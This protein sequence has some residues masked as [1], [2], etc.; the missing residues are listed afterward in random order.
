M[1]DRVE[2]LLDLFLDARLRGSAA[3]I[4]SLI[5]AHPGLEAVERDRLRRLAGLVGAERSAPAAIS[6][7]R[8]GPYRIVR[9][10]GRGGQGTVYLAED[11]RFARRVALKVLPDRAPDAPD[12]PDARRSAARLKREAEVVS[13]LDHP[14]ICVVHEMGSD[15]GER[16]IAMRYVEGETLARKIAASTTDRR[17]VDRILNLVERCA[18]AL[19]V[20][21]E[22]GVVHRDVKPGNIMVTPEGEPVI[23]DFGLA[24][25]ESHA[26]SALTLSGGILGTPAYLSPEQ[27]SSSGPPDRRS[28]VYAL[29]VT[30]YECL[31]HERPFQAPTREQL[32]RRILTE[33]TPDARRL[34]PSV[35]GDLR[36]V[37]ATAMEKDVD[38]RYQTA[39]DLAEELRRVRER[40]PILARPPGIATRGA[41]W[42]QRNP[43]LATMI[44]GLFL[45]LGAALYA[46]D[47]AR[48]ANEEAVVR[49]LLE[50]SRGALASNPGLSLLLAIEAAERRPGLAT[51]QMLLEAIGALQERRTFEARPELLQCLPSPDG[52]WLA[53]V[54][55]DGTVEVR[56][57]EDWKLVA[58][59]S[60]H[61]GG[62]PTAAFSAD[63]NVLAVAGG[64][65][66]CRIWITSSWSAS[67]VIREPSGSLMVWDLDATGRHLLSSPS[68]LD[69][70][71]VRHWDIERSTSQ[72]I[73]ETSADITQCAFDRDGRRVLLVTRSA[74]ARVWRLDAEPPRFLLGVENTV[75]DQEIRAV[76]SPD[77]ERVL[78]SFQQNGASLWEVESARR[79]I[80]L[81]PE[82]HGVAPLAFSADGRRILV[83]HG[84]RRGAVRDASSGEVVCQLD[85]IGSSGRLA[86]FRAD[87]SSVLA[88]SIGINAGLWDAATGESLTEFLGHEDGTM[89][90]YFSK[91]GQTVITSSWDGTVREWSLEPERERTTYRASGGEILRADFDP[92]GTPLAVTTSLG[93][94]ERIDVDTGAVASS[95]P[96]PGPGA[97]GALAFSPDGRFVVTI[98]PRRDPPFAFG[99][100]A[101]VRDAR[102]G[103]RTSEFVHPA[104]ALVYDARFS[105]NGEF[106]VTAANDRKA[107]IW[108]ARTGTLVQELVGHVGGVR[109]AAF[110]P[111]GERIV[112]SSETV[113]DGTVRIW[114]AKSGS[115]L[116]VLRAEADQPMDACFSPD[117]QWAAAGGWNG[118]VCLWDTSRGRLLWRQVH[119]KHVRSVAF[120]PD[121]RWILTASEDPGA[122]LL[123]RESGRSVLQLGPRMSFHVSAFSADGRWIVAASQ[124]DGAAY[125]WPADPLQRAREL[126]PRMLTAAECARYG[127]APEED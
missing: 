1:T 71:V 66:T 97:V 46:L 64:D 115:P 74:G 96:C 51:N 110:D 112:T 108:D 114:D 20:A 127:L 58:T 87:G 33:S 5:A 95:F 63:G 59:L 99:P 42:T 41:R 23:L 45:A 104:D 27:I 78:V 89:G 3:D 60:G 34:N 105:P 119:S 117:G 86:F 38:H 37:L 70:G 123:E 81:G 121:G 12:D 100:V 57:A 80:D 90:A 13:R 103:A 122:Q 30:L 88:S 92:A 61:P 31:T 26:T 11:S 75:V 24:S 19:H 93:S 44:A 32:Y 25:D 65:G 9:E 118:S 73:A 7:E 109:S 21:H 84:A 29:G 82:S 107:R 72:V 43:V 48:T 120:S 76:F 50:G 68:P 85:G 83:A 28:D 56:D 69:S 8:I 2:D 111:R 101:S 94:L 116:L 98:E 55:R 16:Y 91:S 53:T 47:K 17:D 18:R 106:V 35:T 113:E 62:L 126:S 4:E 79:L 22:A 6:R 124:F 10:I 67:H 54:S 49:T 40:E 52:R 102:T 125:V 36:T 77:G 15:G 14:G 39:L